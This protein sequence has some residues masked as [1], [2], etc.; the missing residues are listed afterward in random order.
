[1]DRQEPFQLR[2]YVV[3]GVVA[4]VVVGGLLLLVRPFIFSFA[5]PLTDANYT[6]ASAI[7]AQDGPLKVEIVLN[8]PH[9]LPGEVHRDERVGLTV[10]VSPVGTDAFAV[11]DA[12]SPTN[13]C[14]LTLGPDRLTDCQ[15]S[16]WTFDGIPLD[17]ADPPLVAFPTTVNS[18]AVV[19]DFTHPHPAAAS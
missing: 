5:G 18:G 14:A 13:N 19:V 12:W 2:R 9:G 16:S 11:V 4:A 17:P 7:K 1:M 8:D 15:G 3:A 10:V 6:I